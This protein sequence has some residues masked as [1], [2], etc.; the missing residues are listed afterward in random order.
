MKEKTFQGER[1]AGTRMEVDVRMCK[2]YMWK[3]GW[4]VEGLPAEMYAVYVL[5][6]NRKGRVP[7]SYSLGLFPYLI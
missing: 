3:G 4:M 1:M 2:V 6:G 7:C 5:G